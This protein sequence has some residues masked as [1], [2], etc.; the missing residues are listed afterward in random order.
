MNYCRLLQHR[1]SR[2]ERVAG[3]KVMYIVSEATIEH[4]INIE[5]VLAKWIIEQPELKETLMKSAEVSGL[6]I[7]KIKLYLLFS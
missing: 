6:N 5:G 2:A 1:K 3:I 7:D 4:N